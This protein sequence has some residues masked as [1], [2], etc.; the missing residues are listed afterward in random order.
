MFFFAGSYFIILY[1]LPIYFQSVYGSSPIGSGVKMLALIIPLTIAAIVQGVALSKIGI[2]PLF[3]IL[4]GA[5]GTIGCG[6]F[7][8]MDAHT[9][10]GKWIGYQ[11]I[12]GFCTGWTFQVALENAQVYAAPEDMSQ[13][14]AIINC[15]SCQFVI[16]SEHPP[17]TWLVS[18]TIGG[19]FFLS[20][21]QSAFN[22]QLIK[23]IAIRLPDVDPI[24]ALGIGATQIRQVFTAEQVPLVIDSYTD[25]LKAVF[26]ICIAAFGV[27]TL[28]GA[29]GSWKKLHGD[30]LKKAT[31]GAA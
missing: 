24:V 22:N 28:V 4:G 1:Y 7:Y 6:L 23:A 21:A 19:A 12:V 20:A 27:S 17:H 30:D 31:G 5:L 25:G 11:I 3:W 18:L 13:V 29:L 8:T 26:A 14:T 2:V 9:S 16:Y 15:K 10:T